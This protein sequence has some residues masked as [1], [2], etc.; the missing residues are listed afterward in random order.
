MTK[1]MSHGLMSVCA[2]LL[3]LSSLEHLSNPFR[4]LDGV[5][6]YKLVSFSTARFIATTRPAVSL[7]PVIERPLDWP[8]A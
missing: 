7:G 6:A 3:L 5:M 2:I 1:M 4:F 8:A